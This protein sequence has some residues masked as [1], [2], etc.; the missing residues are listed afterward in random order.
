M[1]YMLHYVGNSKFKT[2]EYAIGT[3][4]MAL[5]MMLPGMISGAACEWLGY[6]NFF[7]YVLLCCIPGMLVIP[8]LKI[9]PDY[10]KKTA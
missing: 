6:E 7:V 2:A 4:I 3:T 1:L 5:G 9:D 8:F 10:G